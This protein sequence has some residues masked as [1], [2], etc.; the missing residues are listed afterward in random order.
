MVAPWRRA[1]GVLK[2]SADEGTKLEKLAHA[3]CESAACGGDKDELLVTAP[4]ARSEIA[5]QFAP[6]SKY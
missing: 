2:M 5:Y 4:P 1:G 3:Q 6:F